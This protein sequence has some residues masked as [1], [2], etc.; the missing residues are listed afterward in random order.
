[1]AGDKAGLDQTRLALAAVAACIVQALG[2]QEPDVQAKV[3][4]NMEKLYMSL[5]EGPVS[6]VGAMETL[7]WTKEFLKEL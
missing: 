7:R 3:E 4:K 1:M 6:N 5:R 2:E